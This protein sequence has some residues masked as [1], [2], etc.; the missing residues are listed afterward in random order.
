VRIGGITLRPGGFFELIGETRTQTDPD[1]ISTRFGSIPL[2]DTAA[3]T[4]ASPAH[5][6][7]FLHGDR[8]LGKALLTAY[9]ESDFLNPVA[10][11]APY[12]WRQYWGSVRAGAWELLGGQAWSLLRPN[13]TGVATEQ[14]LMNTDVIEPAYHVGL[15]GARRRQVRLVRNL[16]RQDLAV[17]WENNGIYVAKL[18]ADRAF[19]HVEAAAFNGRSRRRGASIAAVIPASSKVRLVTQQMWS[20]RDIAEALNLV[21]PLVGGMATLE[22]VEAQLRR[23]FEVYAYAG[24]VYGDRSGGNRTVRQTSTGFNYRVPTPQWHGWM[25]FSLQYS[26]LDRAV[27]D[28][29]SGAVHYLMYRMRFTLI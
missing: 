22:G 19:G 12:R 17:A 8:K 14:G 7:V 6:R 25:L 20:H 29:H 23:Y 5:S 18:A 11:S 10:N 2:A 3:E 24:M 13:R 15:A 28:G 26:Y 4:V 1:S 9:A 27:W 16:G 21:P